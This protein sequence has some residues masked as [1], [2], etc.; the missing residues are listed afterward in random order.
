MA[1][2]KVPEGNQIIYVNPA[3]MELIRNTTELYKKVKVK[4]SIRR[5]LVSQLKNLRK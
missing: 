4:A 1:E 5:M 3:V 2:Q